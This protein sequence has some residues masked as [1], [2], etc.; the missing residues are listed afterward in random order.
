MGMPVS[1]YTLAAAFAAVLALALTVCGFTLLCRPGGGPLRTGAGLAGVTLGG[2]LF[3]LTS[4]GFALAA[5]GAADAPRSIPLPPELVSM[6]VE[7]AVL[8]LSAAVGWLIKRGAAWLHVDREDR[9]VRR[10]EAG[11]EVA[12]SFARE[13]LL[14]R[15]ANLE[16]IQTRSELVEIAATYLAPKLPGILKE[17]RVDPAGLRERLTGRVDLVVPYTGVSVLT[18]RVR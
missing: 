2:V 10:F 11:A 13:T 1:P 18:S 15:G 8:A 14:A 12:L 6:V 17:L 9:L 5:D 7:F 3:L 4:A 16:N